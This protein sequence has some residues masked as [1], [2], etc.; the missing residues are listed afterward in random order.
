MRTACDATHFIPQRQNIGGI[1]RILY[2]GFELLLTNAGNEFGEPE[3]LVVCE[4][5]QDLAQ[6]TTVL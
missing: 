1:G 6:K 3:G 4:I 2:D 5:A